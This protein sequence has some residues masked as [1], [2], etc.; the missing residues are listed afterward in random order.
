LAASPRGLLSDVF[1]QSTSTNDDVPAGCHI[2]V[3]GAIISMD[4]FFSEQC[5]VESLWRAGFFSRAWIRCCI[6]RVPVMYPVA[7]HSLIHSFP[8]NNATPH[9]FLERA[10]FVRPTDNK[11][12]KDDNKKAGLSDHVSFFSPHEEKEE[13]VRA[14][15]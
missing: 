7:N 15:F 1:D 6:P 12:Q 8:N 4:Q 9:R 3:T 10:S 11:L 14:G 2:K 13:G 5:S